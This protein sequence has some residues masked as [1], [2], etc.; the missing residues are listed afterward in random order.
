MY[1][2]NSG[3][4]VIIITTKK[5]HEGKT[6]VSYDGQYGV[7]MN[8]NF[9]EF[10]NGPEFAHYY[11]MADMMDKLANGVITDRSQYTPIFTSQHIEKMTNNDP[12]DGWDNI[13]I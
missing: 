6:K 8:A 12:T 2:L 13:N 7:S 3:G 11:N 10:M 4:G 5:G 9:P 1:G